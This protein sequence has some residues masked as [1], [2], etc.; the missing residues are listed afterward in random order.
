MKL[1]HKL[2]LAFAT[3][4]L[5]VALAGLIGIF[6]L[7]QSVETYERLAQV[8]FGHERAAAA[9]LTDFKVQV[10]E[11]KNVL[12]RGKDPQQLD[13]YWASFQKHEQQ[14]ADATKKLQ[15]ALPPGEAR[16]VIEEFARAHAKMGEGYRAGMEAFKAAG[17]EPAAGDAAVK[18]MDRAPSELLEAATKDIK[19]AA[20]AAEAGAHADARQAV[21]L[22]LILMAAGFGAAVVAGIAISR[23]VTRPLQEAVQVARQVAAGDLTTDIVVASRDENGEMLQAL[24]DMNHSL[25]GIVKQVRASSDTISTASAQIASGNLDLSGRTEQQASSLEQTAA[26]MEQQTATVRRNADNARQANQLAISASGVAVEGGA[27]V[28]KVI[29]TMGAIEQSANRIVDI[30]AVIDGIAFQT[31]ILALN[32]AVEAARAGEQGR[33]FAVVASEVRTLAQRSAS[34]AKEIKSLIEDAVRNVEAGSQLVGEAGATMDKVV[35]SVGRVTEIMTEITEATSE[36][37]RGIEQVNQ[38]IADM[39]QVTQQNAA[40]VEEAAAAAASLHDET[41]QLAQTVS[42]FRI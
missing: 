42:V 30:I 24:K 10:Q 25:A 37:S 19:K 12:L 8:D 41:A 3:L 15:A 29:D 1:R 13:K 5:L 26:A 4:S 35:E 32:A 16:T 11:W 33:G 31:N 18:G 2:P 14:V 27:V 39:D 7:W 20:Q 36:Q 21:S 22:S 34:A 40:L 28:G 6:R 38:A 17:H 23:A 9:I